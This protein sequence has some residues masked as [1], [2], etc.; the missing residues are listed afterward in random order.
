MKSGNAYSTTESFALL[1]VG[2]PKTGKSAVT[3]AFP[4]LR[5]L[6]ADRN[7]TRVARELAKEKTDWS[8]ENP[9]TDKEGKPIAEDKKWLRCGEIVKEF[10]LDQLCKT[11]VI[12][13]GSVVADMALNHS[14]AKRESM[15]PPKTPGKAEYEDYRFVIQAI[16]GF[17]M[18][19]RSSGKMVIWTFHQKVDKDE[20][21]GRFRYELRMP[22]QLAGSFG[23][24]FSDVWATMCERAGMEHKYEI[25]TK[26]TGFHISLGTSLD[27]P[28]KIDVTN[29]SPKQIWELVGKRIAP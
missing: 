12:D 14:I 5:Y 10:I 29:K 26:P 22:G 19:M 1:L 2:E 6:D 18:L 24:Q 15:Q 28:S 27:L 11:I 7:L 25:H 8:Y 21:T 17:H 20:A 3:A 23:G 9:H 16:T 13:G 4:G